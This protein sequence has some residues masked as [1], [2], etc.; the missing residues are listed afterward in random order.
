MKKINKVAIP[1]EEA[2]VQK[3]VQSAPKSSALTTK[4]TKQELISLIN[5]INKKQ[6]VNA[7]CLGATKCIIQRIPTGSISLDIALGGGIPLGRFIHITGGYSSTKTSLSAHIFREAQ[8]AGLTCQWSDVEGTSDD[9]YFRGIGIDV[10]SMLYSRPAG[11]EE[12]TENILDMQRSGLVNLVVWDSL[13]ATKP[14]KILDKN[15][16]DTVQMGIMQVMLDEFFG[17]F[18]ANNN[19]LVREG[20]LPFTLI[21]IN[22][23]REKPTQYGDPEYA[24]GGRAKDYASSI[25]IRLRK[26]D[27]LTQGKGENKEVVGQVV[28]FKIDKNKTY[29]RMN[30]GEFDFYLSENLNNIPVHH[31]DNFKSVILESIVHGVIERGGAWFYLDKEKT[32][33]FQGF[34]EL[35]SYLKATPSLVDDLREKLMSVIAED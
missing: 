17:K 3:S 18:Q 23:L 5:D 7:I 6:G 33:K 19:R 11:L 32:Q 26:G 24:P 1:K 10:N 20:K 27:W 2:K 30:T 4:P 28:K 9:D 15:M 21:G 29:A 34:D 25:D 13:I 16:G 31:I 22:Q 14:N 8:K 35:I 12:C